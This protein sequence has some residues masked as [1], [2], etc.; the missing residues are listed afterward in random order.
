MRITTRRYNVEKSANNFI[1]NT[2]PKPIR[3]IYSSPRF[4]FIF[5]S[6]RATVLTETPI[7]CAVSLML[8]R[9]FHF[10]RKLHRYWERLTLRFMTK[11]NGKSKNTEW[12]GNVESDKN[13]I[14]A[15][16]QAYIRCLVIALTTRKHVT[17]LL[18]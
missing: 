3:L 14:L 16:I 5:L 10:K 1:E 18:G 7:I 6:T 9:A 17:L 2:K 8:I 15:S 4:A 13:C 12:A 11:M